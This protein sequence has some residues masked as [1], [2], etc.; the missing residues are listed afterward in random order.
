VATE[1]K[2]EHSTYGYRSEHGRSSVTLIC[3]FCGSHVTAY[4]WS[5]RG[6]GKKCPTCGALHYGSGY[7]I[8]KI[9]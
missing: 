2:K 7:S 1:E 9:K 6:G 5:L 4:V 8:K 3:P